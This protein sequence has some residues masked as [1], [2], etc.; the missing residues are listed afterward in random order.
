[1][2][3]I[4]L[5]KPCK[6]VFSFFYGDSSIDPAS[7]LSK[8]GSRQTFLCKAMSTALLKEK[9]V[10]F[11]TGSD[12][13]LY[14]GHMAGT[15]GSCLFQSEKN[16]GRESPCF[17]QLLLPNPDCSLDTKRNH[18][19]HGSFWCS[20]SKSFFDTLLQVFLHFSSREKLMI[21]NERHP[22]WVSFVT[23][24]SVG[25]S[26]PRFV[27]SNEPLFVGKPEANR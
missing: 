8:R 1:M 18:A 3:G 17:C 22:S 16:S 5:K 15:V 23:I 2:P 7:I 20:V 21:E 13:F 27:G 26:R 14:S 4:H 24:V 9:S 6:G 19:M 11:S 12:F 10:V 25:S